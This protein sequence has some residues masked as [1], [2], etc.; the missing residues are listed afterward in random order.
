M[1]LVFI[2]NPAEETHAKDAMHAKKNPYEEYG[3]QHEGDTFFVQ[4]FPYLS[5][6]ALFAP[7]A[8]FA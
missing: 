2:P 6:L 3:T 1:R 5:A 8:P 7:F 4:S